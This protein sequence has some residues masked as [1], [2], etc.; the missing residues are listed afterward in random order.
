MWKTVPR[1]LVVYF[2]HLIVGDAGAD[3][4]CTSRVLHSDL[5]SS[6]RKPSNRSG[7]VDLEAFSTSI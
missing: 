1:M 2:T 4:R 5:P 6:L 3:D 7:R